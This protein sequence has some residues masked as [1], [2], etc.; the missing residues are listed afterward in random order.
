VKTVQTWE[1]LTNEQLATMVVNM[2]HQTVIHYTLWFMEVEHQLGMPKALEILKKA[3]QDSYT[4][5]MNR[6]GKTLGFKMEGL[7]PEPLLKMPRERITDLLDAVAANWLANDG[8]WFQAVEMTSGMNDA[9]RCNDSCWA[10]FARVEAWSIKEALQLDDHP[11]LEGLKR[12]L[13]FRMYF[14]IN[15]SSFEDDS[16]NSFIYRMD[17]CRVQSARKRRGLEDY[18][19]KSAGLVEY[20][21]FASTIDS[22]IV[23]ECIGCPPDPHPEEWWCAWRFS[24]PEKA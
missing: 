14:R 19:C 3:F 10:R 6:L 5:Q 13:R 20:P 7:V 24:L 8:V 9:K 17:D 18:A 4:I 12:A 15:K 11:G 23:T 16:P 1:E 22:R 21:V 2:L